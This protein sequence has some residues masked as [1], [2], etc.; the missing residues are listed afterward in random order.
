M[1]VPPDPAGAGF[2][3]GLHQRI[4]RLRRGERDHLDRRT[5]LNRSKGGGVPE[6]EGVAKGIGG[7]AWDR[8]PVGMDHG[9]GDPTRS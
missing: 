6:P 8:I 1:G 5:G 9:Q 2:G 4:D 7:S 3:H